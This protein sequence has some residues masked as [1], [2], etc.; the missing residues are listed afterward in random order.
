MSELDAAAVVTVGSDV[1]RGVPVLRV[2][3]E[4][5]TNVADEVRRALLPWLDGLRGPGVLDLTGVRF[6][7]STGLSLLIEAA[8]RRPAKLVLATAQR[9]VLR[10]LQLTG[11]SALLPTHPTVDLAV[12]AQLGAA[13]AGMPSTA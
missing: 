2:A 7:A 11:M 12:D 10:P 9:G 4:I 8:R 6:M 13:L 3:G 1:V 5:D